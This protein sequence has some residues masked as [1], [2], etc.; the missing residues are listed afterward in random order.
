MRNPTAVCA[1][2]VTDEAKAQQLPKAVC[3]TVA[4]IFG[5]TSTVHYGPTKF[6]KKWMERC[7]MFST[8]W[9]GV[10]VPAANTVMPKEQ[11]S[12]VVFVVAKFL[13]ISR[14]HYNQKR[15]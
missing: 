5:V 15:K 10:A 3:C 2:C 14:V 8:L 7:K 9:P 1:H 11:Q 13:C 6:L 12:I 4:V